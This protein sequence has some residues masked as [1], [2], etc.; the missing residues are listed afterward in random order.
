MN[1]ETPIIITGMHRSGTSLMAGFI[2][3]SGIDLG[4]KLLGARSSNIYGH[5]EDVEILEFH[6]EILERQFGHQM[7][8]PQPPRLMDADRR[9]AV[10]LISARQ[11]KTFWGWKDPRTCLFLDFWNELLPAAWY[12]FIV[13]RPDLVLH[14]LGKRNNTRFFHFW[15][16]NTFLRSWLLYNHECYRFYLGHR[17][18]CILVVLEHVLECP[19]SVVDLLSE[20]LAYDLDEAVFRASYD[21]S[22]LTTRPKQRRL[23]SPLLWHKCVSLYRKL[24][25]DADV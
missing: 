5:F 25:Q 17:S 16:H 1:N 20:R 8:V 3:R 18:R 11:H 9:R 12:L 6:R 24:S 22:V 15:V 13:R 4:D 7:W 21:A 2:H 10:A 14:S 19:A 23:A